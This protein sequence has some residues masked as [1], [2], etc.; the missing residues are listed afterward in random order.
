MRVVIGGIAASFC[1]AADGDVLK[2]PVMP[3]SAEF[4]TFCKGVASDSTPLHQT[5][6]P[7]NIAGIT[8]AM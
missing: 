7:Y 8:H 6:A 5:S 3:M 4:W 1:S 2:P